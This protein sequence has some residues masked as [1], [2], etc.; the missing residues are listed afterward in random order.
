MNTKFEEYDDL[1]VNPLTSGML[2]FH[3]HI[4]SSA[5]LAA[6]L[7]LSADKPPNEWMH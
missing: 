7:A 2:K 4:K 5:D 3:L 6:D 1:Y